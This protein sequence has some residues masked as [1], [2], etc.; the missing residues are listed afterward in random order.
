MTLQGRQGKGGA[1]TNRIRKRGQDGECTSSIASSLYEK[2]VKPERVK[3]F[4]ST[5]K[6]RCIG[7]AIFLAMF[8]NSIPFPGK[9]SWT[10]IAKL[11]IL[12]SKSGHC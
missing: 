5:T 9:S 4:T 1:G 12:L 7:E 6:R 2:I 10:N 11:E 8:E 3:R